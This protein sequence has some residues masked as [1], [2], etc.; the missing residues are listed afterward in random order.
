[1]SPELVFVLRLA[2]LS[3]VVVGLEFA[4]GHRV[5]S[6]RN[7]APQAQRFVQPNP[8]VRLRTASSPSQRVTINQVQPSPVQVGHPIVRLEPLPHKADYGTEKH[9]A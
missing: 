3:A 6:S 4:F 8:V 1:M 7:R 2:L 9:A 5:Q